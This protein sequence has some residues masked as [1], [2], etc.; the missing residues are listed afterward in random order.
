MSEKDWSEQYGKV[1]LHESKHEEISSMPLHGLARFSKK[2]LI[3]EAGPVSAGEGQP[4]FPPKGKKPFPPP[5]GAPQ[6][7]DAPPPPDAGGEGQ[8]PPPAEGDAGGDPS[9]GG[10]GGDPNQEGG[11]QGQ[12]NQNGQGQE[13]QDWV[14]IKDSPELKD[15]MGKSVSE[16][17]SDMASDPNKQNELI[18]T[19]VGPA[20]KTFFLQNAMNK[21]IPYQ[22]IHNLMKGGGEGQGGE[23]SPEGDGQE[24][25]ETPPPAPEGDQGGQ[26]PMGMNQKK[27]QPSMESW[28][29]PSLKDFVKQINE[30]YKK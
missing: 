20:I 26:P 29:R 9:M 12:P 23:Q 15:F 8:L 17:Y 24:G 7:A 19:V 16:L 25:G 27:P 14:A 10:E 28:K 2:D 1:V 4:P 13:N 30:N 22:E 3:T 21:N 18:K 5:A 6:G 11:D